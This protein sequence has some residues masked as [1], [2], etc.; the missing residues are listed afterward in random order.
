MSYGYRFLIRVINAVFMWFIIA[1]T[2]YAINFVSQQLDIVK[3]N[4]FLAL[5]VSHLVTGIYIIDSLYIFVY[6][7]K[8]ILQARPIFC[9][10]LSTIYSKK[11]MPQHNG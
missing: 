5:I 9:N 1:I 3:Q 2:A 8:V 11:H 6:I 4:H 10:K 7:T